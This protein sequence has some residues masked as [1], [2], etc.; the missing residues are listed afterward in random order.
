M[1]QQFARDGGPT[2]RKSIILFSDGTGNSSAKLFKTNVWRLYEAVDLGPTASPEDMSVQIAYYDNGVGTSSVRPLAIL[3][4]IFGFGLKRNILTIYRYVCRN[5]QW[6]AGQDTGPN[7]QQ[8]GDHIYGF[9]FSRGAFTMRLVISLIAKEG[10][11]TYKDER[12]LVRK[13]LDAY[14]GFCEDLTPRFLRAPARMV[15]AVRKLV[16]TRW[17]RLR[18]QEVYNRDNNY[19]PVIR[20]IGVWDTVAAY[21]GPFVELT[22]AIDNWIWPLSMPNYKLSPRIRQARHALS[23]DD[24]RDAFHPLL[25]DEDHERKLIK[26]RANQRKKAGDPTKI[27]ETRLQQ[28]WFSGMHADVGGGYPDESLSYVSLLWMIGEAK[29]FGLR[30]LDQIVDRIEDLANSFG[31]I[32][33]SRAGLGAYYRYQP[34]KIA[35]FLHPLDKSTLS[36]RDPAI[37]DDRG[38]QK[39]LLLKANIHESVI[40]RIIS[41]TDSYAPLN[42]PARFNVIPLLRRRPNLPPLV[43]REMRER[44]GVF[45]PGRQSRALERRAL[46]RH[47][48][49]E[50]IWNWVWGR[51]IVYFITLFLTLA[52]AFMPL[53]VGMAPRAPLF[54]DGRAWIGSVINGA[55][56]VLPEFARPLID[57]YSR[58]PFYFLLLFVLILV[59]LAVGR[60]LEAM[61]RDRIRRLWWSALASNTAPLEGR[62]ASR[63]RGLR[64]HPRYQAAWQIFKWHVMPNVLGPIML[65]LLF[66]GALA[67]VTQAELTVLERGTELCQPT[68][69]H[70]LQPLIR[71]RQDFRTRNLC[72][73]TGRAVEEG[74]HYSVTFTVTR[75]WSDGRMPPAPLASPLGRPAHSLPTLAGVPLRRVMTAP[76][77]Q[78]LI[79]IRPSPETQGVFPNVYIFP[80]ELTQDRSEANV[81]RAEFDAAR[82]G[83]LLLFANDSVFPFRVGDL[84]RGYFYTRSAGGGNF[85]EACVMIERADLTVEERRDADKVPACP[86]PLQPPKARHPAVRP[87]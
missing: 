19:Q 34:R 39:G 12:D 74:A 6:G 55:T 31:P 17:R 76:Y 75:P 27:D 25:W 29:K 13:S 50:V 53:W 22:R 87:R 54:T 14:R 11:V 70:R 10:I 36:M 20:F 4:G 32:H 68:D 28:V 43:D 44:I 84:D 80:L 56:A 83:E 71:A 38:R 41:G 65:L 58:N 78:P 57:T 23:I 64:D 30:V 60:L 7:E 79:E 24:E 48:R 77:L 61:L 51:R 16:V 21:G 18:R 9:G 26:D 72:H 81:Y 15:R 3:G 40:A 63:L 86:P 33:N 85:G 59:F 67:L 1:P 35:A 42:L 73:A 8:L 2:Y 66:F 47:K 46:E 5:Y 62:A 45:E 69:P 49:Q 82:S 37:R 52:L